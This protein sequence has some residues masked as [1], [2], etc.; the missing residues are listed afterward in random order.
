MVR[1]KLLKYPELYRNWQ[2]LKSLTRP[3]QFYRA[4]N[5]PV[6]DIINCGMPRSGSTLLHN[7]IQEVIGSKDNYNYC[8]TEKEYCNRLMKSS[9][10]YHLSKIHIY[11]PTAANRISTNR[12]IGF[13]T[14]R[15]IRDII[16]SKIQKRG[17]KLEQE[18]LYMNVRYAI[19]IALSYVEIKELHIISYEDLFMN[20]ESVIKR[21]ANILNIPISD[22]KIKEIY[23]NTSIS[24]TKNKIESGVSDKKKENF[25]LAESGLHK[26][27]INNPSL[28]KWKNI[29]TEKE[30]KF[31]INNSQ[32]Y[33]DYFG[34]T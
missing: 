9:K 4:I 24:S 32:D 22:N 25:V 20:R 1:K 11:S 33:F 21:I 13:F 27:H 14:H 7:I 15:D 2:V 31:I 19:N 34:Y 6:K 10:K 8:Q 16:A 30:E 29:L 23:E 18:I 12:S 3:A 26:N 17:I 28:G 5:Y